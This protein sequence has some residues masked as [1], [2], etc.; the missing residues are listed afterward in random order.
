MKRTLSIVLL[1]SMLASLAACGS[2]GDTT[3]DTTAAGETTP[4]ETLS[5]EY[6]NPGVDYGGETFK[7]LD[8]HTDTYKWQARG[9]SELNAAEESGEP[10]NDAQYKRNVKVEEELNIKLDTYLHEKPSE[11]LIK[12]VMA[13]EDEVDAAFVFADTTNKLLSDKG[14]LQDLKKISTIDLDAS[15]WNQNALETFTLGGELKVATGDIS[16]YSS[17]SPMMMFFNKNVADEF[18]ITDLY[19]LV[20]T[21]KWTWDKC[22]EYCKM[23]AS[24][25]NGDT[26]YDENDRYGMAEQLWIVSSL[27]SSADIDFTS[28]DKDGNITM[29]LNNERT[30]D[31]ISFLI[32]FLN[33]RQTN[34]VS[35][36]FESKYANVFYDLHIPMFKNDQILFNLQQLLISFELRAMDTDYGLL[37]LPKF[38]E[39]EN[40]ATPI[41]PSWTT[42]LCIPSTNTDLERTGVVIEALAFYSQQYVT[43]A[44]IDT[45]IRHKSLRDEDS[46][47]MLE[48]ILDSMKYDIA[49]IYNWGGVSYFMNNL[50]TNNN[51]NFASA[52]AS[53][54]TKVEKALADTMAQFA[55]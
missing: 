6:K 54:E 52:Y 50:G 46:A 27:V 41:S 18:K 38:G 2:S 12:L 25:V 10:I 30:A 15:W 47:E 49:H 32:P 37:P 20:R 23:V 5:D 11:E 16:L 9:Y 43:P 31:F 51:P 26:V 3:A 4:A 53:V 36:A 14:M 45:T 8:F 33:D 44:Y 28:R 48:L 55:E 40:Y 35:Q 13:G 24:D 1:M 39:Q 22:A 19:D 42:L 29:A 7:F 21:D 17:F 34:C